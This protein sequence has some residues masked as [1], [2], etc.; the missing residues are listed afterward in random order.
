MNNNKLNG[1]DLLNVGIY[2]AIYFVIVFAI[3]MLGMVP[4]LYPMLVVFCPLI[5]GIV[6]MLFLT[7]VKKFGMIWIMSVLMGLLMLVCG[8]GVYPLIVSVVTGLLADLIYRSG[9]YKSAT[10]AVLT[11][12]VFSLWIFANFLLFYL[13]HDS[14]MATREEMIGPEYVETLNKILPLWS[15]IIL[16]IVCFVFGLLGGLLGRKMLKKHL[17]KAGIA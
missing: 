8:M 2:S 14:Y 17:A 11:H 7:R 13:N 15:W 3:A 4:I 12:G 10:K 9:N 1:K 16:L 6:F 5:G